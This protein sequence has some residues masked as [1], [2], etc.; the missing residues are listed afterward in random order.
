VELED[1]GAKSQT[2]NFDDGTA[3]YEVDI[4]DGLKH[5]NYFEY[6]PSGE[7]KVKGKYKNDQKDGTWKY[8]NEDGDLVK[9]ERWKKGELV[10]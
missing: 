9:R 6:H 5:G 7:L 4:K 3:K 1:L 2:E 10:N 8:Y